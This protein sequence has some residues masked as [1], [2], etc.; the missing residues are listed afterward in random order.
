VGYKT[1]FAM[2]ESDVREFR[3]LLATLKQNVDRPMDFLNLT[4]EVLVRETMDAFRAERDPNTGRAWVDLADAT[5]ANRRRGKLM[6]RGR[7][8][9]V[10]YAHYERQGRR[11]VGQGSHRTSRVVA[12][13]SGFK[14]L[15]DTGKFRGSVTRQTSINPPAVAV[16]SN[17]VGA[18]VHQ[19]GN[20]NHKAWG[21][22]K[23]NLP[24]RPWLPTSFT[25]RI[26]STIKQALIAQIRKGKAAK[27][28]HEG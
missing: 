19:F 21:K 12:L 9:R 6:T 1:A 10:R 28:V 13:Y 26:A 4:G 20:P 14:I 23:S 5:K 16:G 17:F 11:T 2:N 22:W 24:A 27:Y 25:P 7:A 3:A 15:Q 18:A 8:S